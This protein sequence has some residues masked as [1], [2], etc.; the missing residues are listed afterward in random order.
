MYNIKFHFVSRRQSKIVAPPFILNE[1]QTQ[2]VTGGL[3]PQP[4]PPGFQLK[5]QSDPWR[6]GTS[7]IPSQLAVLHENG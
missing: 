5:R 4:E 2:I 7:L 3:N 1:V 6:V